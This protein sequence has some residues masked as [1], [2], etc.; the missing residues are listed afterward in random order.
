MR[1][2]WRP[3]FPEERVSEEPARPT[4][5]EARRRA[6]PLTL[7]IACALICAG[8]AQAAGPGIADLVEVGDLS[9]LVLS[10]DGRRAA[11]R[12][13]RA[14]ILR[15][16]HDLAWHVAD[17]ETG[18]V[19][20]VGGGGDPVWKDP[21]TVAAEDAFWS[22]DGSALF[23]RALV[24]GGIGLWRAASDGSGARA[25]VREAGDVLSVERSADG[26]SLLYALGPPRADIVAAERAEYDAGILVDA[27]VDPAQNAYKGGWVNGRLATQRLAG[28][29]FA[30]TGLTGDRPERYR[31]LDMESLASGDAGREGASPAPG[32]PE[33]GPGARSGAGDLATASWSGGTGRLVVRR[34][35]GADQACAAEACR[36]RR[37]DWLAW[38][39]AGTRLL[40]AA[41]DGQRSQALRLWDP[42]SGSVRTLVE[43][44]GLVGGGRR[45]SPCAL[46]EG[47][48]VCV[49]EGPVSPPRLER[50]DL[51]TGARRVLFDPNAGLR[52]LPMPAV[53]RLS[54]EAGGHS[55]TGVLLTP[56]SARG[57][58]PLFVTYYS[59]EGHLRGGVGDEYPLV[60]MAGAGMAVLCINAAPVVSAG[61]DALRDYRVA[62]EG[63]AAA[64]ARLDRRGLVD[65]GRVG[66]GGLSFG[67]EVT[68]WTAMHSD[69][70][71][72]ASIASSS[73]EPGYY[74][75]NGV[76]GRDVHAILRQV[77]GLGAPD[78]TPARW[79]E[80][81][82][83]L[84]VE[85]LRTPLLMQLAEQEAR[86]SAELHARLT[87]SGTP[88]ELYVFPDEPHIK[89]QPRH[90]LAAYGRNL[91]W[92]RY[93]LQDHSDPDPLK[94]DQYRRW[95]TLRAAASRDLRTQSSRVTRSRT[96]K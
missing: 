48:A 82:P 20:R 24:D 16:S 88:A 60:P 42:R 17:L 12:V 35:S 72:A 70:L 84:N 41:A 53:E 81:S 83:A 77:W 75:L 62:L 51:A 28:R 19:R 36:D 1:F 29:W 86:Y 65:R 74:W 55:F 46:S 34:A 8:G 57:R 68:L 13:E 95:D 93:W 22:P 87:H 3:V 66:M 45:H 21:G 2:A 10:P 38:D 5:G 52:A 92:F 63:I 47:A 50:I 26:R 58:L 64:V 69:L 94:A 78:E 90:K 89:I 37:I 76:R 54:W 67:S 59:C 27:R 56:L 39:P 11:F 71:A 4:L 49:L 44:D 23:Y 80:V 6:G 96:R 18:I 43:A 91:D 79:K 40:F 9:G 15:G 7:F 85:K 25:V 61:Q 14:S 73:L 32:P 33:S 31:R 30:R